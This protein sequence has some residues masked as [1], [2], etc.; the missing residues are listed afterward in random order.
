MIWI[1]LTVERKLETSKTILMPYETPYL[2]DHQDDGILLSIF[3]TNI[4][5]PEAAFF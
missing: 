5:V 1:S 3:N 2:G 4:D